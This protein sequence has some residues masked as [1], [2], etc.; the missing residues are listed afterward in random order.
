LNIAA[1]VNV[2]VDENNIDRVVTDVSDEAVV[3]ARR[4]T[5]G[6]NRELEGVTEAEHDQMRQASRADQEIDEPEP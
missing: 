5:Q 4:A 3:N 1:A 2:K 6:K